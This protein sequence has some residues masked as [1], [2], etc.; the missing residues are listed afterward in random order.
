M[1][2]NG[3]GVPDYWA[4]LFTSQELRSQAQTSIT[5]CLSSIQHLYKWQE[6]N[7]RNIIQDLE[8]SIVPGAKFVES[9][10]E[11]CGLRSVHIQKELLHKAKKKSVNF[12][13]LK[14]ARSSA[15]SQ[16]SCDYQKRRMYDISK[17][18]M[19]IGQAILNKKRNSKTLLE[20]LYSLKK[21]IEANYPK[22]SFSR[23]NKQ[24]P[25]A[26]KE[27]FE[28]F[29]KIFNPDSI[30]NPF[31]SYD[32]KHR[33]FLLVQLLYWTGARSGEI[34][35]M[36]LDDIDYDLNTPK[37]KIN[38]R[39]DDVA[40]SR[41]YQP[42]TKT[43][44]REI[45][46]PI[47][48]RNELD[49]YINKIRSKSASSKTHPYIFIS[50]KGKT[51]GKPVS[52][53]TFYNRVISTVKSISP[54]LFELVKRHGFRHLFNEKLSERVDVHNN[55]LHQLIAE[56]EI[57]KLPQRVAELK[58]DLISEQ[59]EIEIRMALNGHSSQESARPYIE[60]HVKKKAQ[61]VHKEMMQDMSQF[62]S[63]TRGN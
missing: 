57:N 10:K 18:I 7:N 23:Y 35:S 37:V 36:T 14:L 58:K 33:N 55:K 42:V 27:T 47:W 41:K 53:S 38:R 40:D 4:T 44:S 1:L 11:H 8:N 59:Q 61:K 17:F 29:L 34:L 21:T 28:E 54:D 16:V 46:I 13:N 39:H 31:K 32:L 12:N 24:L 45:I 3:L 49:Y 15:L 19:F 51:L 62:I 48:L 5:S 43:K 56:A 20:E 63:K 30:I 52:D 60:R 22:S 2:I 6:I 26:D 25:H 50:H 9:V